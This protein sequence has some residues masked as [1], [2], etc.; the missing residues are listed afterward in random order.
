MPIRVGHLYIPN[1]F[2]RMD[3]EKDTHVPIILVRP[4]MATVG[5]FIYVK[6]GRLMFE[7]EEYRIKFFVSSFEAYYWCHKILL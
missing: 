6:Q 5:I 7:M 4:F 2:V 3:I 1:D